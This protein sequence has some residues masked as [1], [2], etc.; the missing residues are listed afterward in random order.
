MLAS[1]N[2]NNIAQ[3]QDLTLEK[4]KDVFSRCFPQMKF[5]SSMNAFK[6]ALFYG[7]YVL[8]KWKSD[9]NKF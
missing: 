5:Y 6:Y 7:F 9:Y 8:A 4:K 3:I 1:D 2:K